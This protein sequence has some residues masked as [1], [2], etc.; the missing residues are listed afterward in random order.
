MKETEQKQ[1][2]ENWLRQY[3]ALLFKVVRVYAFTDDDRDDLFQEIA[4]QMWHSIP[5]FRKESAESTWIYRVAL[6]TAMRWTRKERRHHDGRQP[7]EGIEHLLQEN[8]ENVDERLTWL[9]AEIAKLPEIDRS[10]TLLMLD[11]FSYKE[12]AEMTG[13]TDS[14]IGVKIHRIKKHLIEKSEK[15]EYHGV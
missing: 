4:I 5:N 7:V 9:Y 13:I 1:I 8:V 12:M 14:N 2:F 11:G 10:L 15:Y 6:N 3:K